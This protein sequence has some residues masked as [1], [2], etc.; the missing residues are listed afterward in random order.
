MLQHS[1][2][3]GHFT[4]LLVDLAEFLTVF[5]GQTKKRIRVWDPF[6]I[7]LNA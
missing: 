7:S 1:V 5:T 2:L 3:V 4:S 6:I